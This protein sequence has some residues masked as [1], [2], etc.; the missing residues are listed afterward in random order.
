MHILTFKSPSP[1]W[2][3]FAC[4]PIHLECF[5]AAVFNFSD[6]HTGFKPFDRRTSSVKNFY[7]GIQI[8]QKRMRWPS[9]IALIKPRWTSVNF[10]DTKITQKNKITSDN[11]TKKRCM[12]IREDEKYDVEWFYSHFVSSVYRTMIAIALRLAFVKNNSLLPCM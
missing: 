1:P 11:R 6:R 2:I 8:E 4:L 7:W 10:D 3:S 12:L 5:N 9:L